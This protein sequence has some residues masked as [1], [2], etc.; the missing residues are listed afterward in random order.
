MHVLQGDYSI[1]GCLR[2]CFVNFRGFLWPVVS[3]H[4]FML[5]CAGS[6]AD[7]K[8]SVS[9]P[10]SP[11]DSLAHI[12]VADGLKVELVAHEPNVIDPVEIRFDEDGRIWVVEMRDYP[13]GS[14]D[15]K[16]RSR[17]SVLTDNDG[18]GFFETATVF[19]DNLKFATGLQPWKGGVFVTMAGEV[20]YMKDTTGDGR[21][22]LAETWF[23][24]FAEENTQLRANHPRFALDNHIYVAN[25]LR[26]GTIVDATIPYATP[27]SI[28]G[29]DFR[30]DPLTRK[31]EAVSGTSQFGLTFDDYGN[32]FLCTNRNPAIHVVLEDRFLK[33]NPLVAVAAVTHDVAKAGDESRVFPITRAWT[34]SHLHA[35][36]F[37]AACGLEIYRGDALPPK[38]Y[39]NIF[40]CEPTGHLVHCE[41]MK[42]HGVTFTSTPAETNREFLAS[43]DEWFSPVN[44]QVG[45]DGALYV[46]DMY[47]AVIEHPEWMPTELRE[48]PDLLAGNDRGRIYRVVPQNFRRPPVPY[49][50]NIPSARLIEFLAHPN[51]WWRESAARLL[52]ERQNKGLAPQLHDVALRHPSHLARIH[53]LRVLQSFR[54]VTRKLLDGPLGD[55]DP[56]VVEQ[57]ISVAES[58]GQR[59]TPKFVRGDPRVQFLALLTNAV[60]VDGP[61]QEEVDSWTAVAYLV[62]AGTNADSALVT[63]LQNQQ[64]IEANLEDPKKFIVDL[65]RLAAATKKERPSVTAMI[66]AL[67]ANATYLRLGLAS[68]FQQSR[69]DGRWSDEVHLRLPETTRKALDAAFDAARADAINSK[70]AVQ[71]RCEAID[72]VAEM[73]NAR[74]VLAPLALSDPDPAIRA[75][76]IRALPVGSSLTVWSQLTDNYSR[77]TP[78]VK[79]A[80]IDGIF[81]SSPRTALLLDAIAAGRIQPAALDTVRVNQLLHHRDDEIRSRA[82]QLLADIIPADRQ[83]VLADYKPVLSMP[84]D[85]ARGRG[86]FTQ[87]CATCH[88]VAGVGIDIAPDISDSREKTPEQLFTDILQ[89]NRAVDANYFSYTLITTQGQVHTGI[90]VTETSTSI[91]MKLTEG[92]TITLR[93]DEIDELQSNAVSFMPDG[94]EKLIPPQDMADLISFLK[95]WRYLEQQDGPSSELP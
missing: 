56:R 83:R 18:D 94:M 10:L 25:G 51:A 86:V 93:R 45:P 72:L 6:H 16:T 40:V 19:A 73:R 76:V 8:L 48:R 65:T 50:S 24:G 11:Q 88:R 2:I 29:M 54:F 57:A 49:L 13:T 59:G 12:V 77:E 95:N 31:C 44:L 38:Y 78:M 33:K 63:C 58:T 52:V 71:L 34:T 91:T 70:N 81:A 82:E 92:K 5:L 1:N 32:R 35:G 14:P 61:P 47:R 36:Q 28:S 84:A 9:S 41:I 67:L 46:V 21:A 55:H 85:A 43:R 23:R 80:I 87:H 66:D 68:Y 3:A 7:E 4:C 39:G 69:R 79:S 20:A 89:P 27:L 90:L 62:A 17:I 74:L 22:D 64:L 75:H 42:P 60:V 37:T 15:G 30:F 26:G 53:A